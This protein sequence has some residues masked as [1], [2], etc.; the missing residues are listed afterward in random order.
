MA[1]GEIELLGVSLDRTALQVGDTAH[2]TLAMRA[3]VTPTHILMPYAAVGERAYRWT[4]D[5][6][7]LSTDW[8]PG[9]VIVE[10]YEIALPF[11]MP[12]GEYP[13]SLGVAD[14]TEGRDLR[15]RKS[16]ETS[17]VSMVPIG[18]LRVEVPQLAPAT[19]SLPAWADFGAQ[20]ALVGASASGNGQTV[21]A[22]SRAWT[23]PLAVRPAD[24]VELLRPGKAREHGRHMLRDRFVPQAE[25][26]EAQA[27]DAV[28]KPLQRRI[29]SHRRHRR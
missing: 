12:P 25:V 20:I 10:R 7:A 18:A 23:E 19:S 28:E 8:R 15:L 21:Q 14:L 17:E 16:V 5:S 13:L 1:E 26:H 4:T 2:L 3:L 22:P 27:D 9:E 11:S 24:G 6:R 29:H